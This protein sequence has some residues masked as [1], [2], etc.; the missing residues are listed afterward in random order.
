MNLALIKVVGS[1]KLKDVYHKTFIVLQLGK[2]IKLKGAVKKGIF[3]I[4]RYTKTDI[5]FYQCFRQQARKAKAS[6]RQA[7]EESAA[8][9]CRL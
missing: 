9:F 4:I 1:D 3:R 8:H 7:S 6:S 5:L 2:V